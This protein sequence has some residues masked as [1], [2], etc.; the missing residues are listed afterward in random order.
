MAQLYADVAEEGVTATEPPVDV[1]AY[2]ELFAPNTDDSV[3]AFADDQLI[4]G[5]H[6]EVSKHG[7][8]KVGVVVHRD[9]RGRGVGAALL[10]ETISQARERGLSKL[11]SECFAGSAEPIAL[12]HKVGFVDEG[13]RVK[14]YRRAG[15]ELKDS[16]M[17]GL[18]L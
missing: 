9:W 11:C 8:G 1:Q 14:Q 4:G 5:T 7:F 16:V 6:T 10:E 18:V 3:V 2:A 13:L 15:G 12:Y 17:M